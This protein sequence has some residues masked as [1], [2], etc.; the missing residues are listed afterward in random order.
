MSSVELKDMQANGGRGRLAKSTTARARPGGT[1][2]AFHKRAAGGAFTGPLNF[3]PN[4]RRSAGVQ[5]SADARWRGLYAGIT[6]VR[7]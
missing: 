4:W 3:R 5:A 7:R 6:A 2:V 1:R